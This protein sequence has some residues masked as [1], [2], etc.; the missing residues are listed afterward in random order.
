M[1]CCKPDRCRC[2][3]PTCPAPR[4]PL[5]RRLTQA[6]CCPSKEPNLRDAAALWRSLTALAPGVDP[7]RTV[8]RISGTRW[9]SAVRSRPPHYP[10]AAARVAVT[11]LGGQ[12][13]SEG[14]GSES[15][16]IGVYLIGKLMVVSFEPVPGSG[17]WPNGGEGAARAAQ[18]AHRI[19]P[20]LALPPSGG[21]VALTPCSPARH[22]AETFSG[23]SPTLSPLSLA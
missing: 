4:A 6:L 22:C 2:V 7:A 20:T 10:A 12:K 3:P 8:R 5:R 14:L 23:W 9:R 19:H 16:R 11:R 18:C 17:C 13:R 15:P 21:V 1:R